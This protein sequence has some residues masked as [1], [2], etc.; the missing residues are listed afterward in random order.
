L[1]KNP[2]NLR[3]WP[4]P[5]LY[6]YWLPPVVVM[7]ALLLM[8]GSQCSPANTCRW[9]G[10]L[11]SHMVTLAPKQ[12]VEI[13][14]YLRKLGHL[15]AYGV[16]SFLWWRAFRGHLGYRLRPCLLGA[17][18]LCLLVALADEGHQALVESRR[19]SFGDVALDLAGAGLAALLAMAVC[20]DRLRG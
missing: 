10:W 5:P 14:H 11:L 8:S 13:N 4:I 6:Y 9:V 15:T 17:L 16:L 20:S 7:A 19:A 1:R 2:I 3:T 18:A 12:L